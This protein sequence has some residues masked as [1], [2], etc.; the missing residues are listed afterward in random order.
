MRFRGSYPL[1]TTPRL[2]EA[3]DFYVLHFAFEPLFQATWFVYLASPDGPAVAFMHPDHPS[4]PPGP[5]AF[6]GLGMIFTIEVE[7]AE[8]AYRSLVASGAPLVHPLTD[9]D[10]GQRRFMTRDPSG[11]LVDV[12][13]Q[14]EAK[15]EFWERYA[16]PD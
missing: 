13:Q 2:F 15:P 3:R 11:M 14:T 9:E 7:D 12:V 6:S 5:E 1:I 8:A 10:W 16:L 4:S